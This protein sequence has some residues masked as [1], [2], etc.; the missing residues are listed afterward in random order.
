MRMDPIRALPIY[1]SIFVLRAP[2]IFRHS[3]QGKIEGV[4]GSLNAFTSE[5]F[6]CYLTKI[7]AKHLPLALDVLSDMVLEAAFGPQRPGKREI[8][9]LRRN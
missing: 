7:I 5:E 1:W 6:T 9:Y 3:N 2:E 8:G 4:G